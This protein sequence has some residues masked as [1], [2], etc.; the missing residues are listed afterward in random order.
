MFNF[1]TR[2]VVKSRDLIWYDKDYEKWLSKK[3]VNESGFD[4]P[5]VYFGSDTTTNILI[6]KET[7][8]NTKLDTSN[9]KVYNEMKLLVKSRRIQGEG[10]L[11]L[12]R[13]SMLEGANVTF[14]L[15][16]NYAEPK[17]FHEAYNPPS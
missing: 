8:L 17:K 15:A 9:M 14:F 4:D 7:D 11:N 16:D 1:K 3:K 12:G 13:E 6:S 5:V 10:R 2:Q